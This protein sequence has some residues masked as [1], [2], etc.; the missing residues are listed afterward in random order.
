MMQSLYDNHRS[1]CL[2]CAIIQKREPLSVYWLPQKLLPP[3]TA[4]VCTSGKLMQ[5]TRFIV[6]RGP[7]GTPAA[8]TR[9]VASISQNKVIQSRQNT[10]EPRSRARQFVSRTILTS[11]NERLHGPKFVPEGF[12]QDL[13]HGSSTSSNGLFRGI[14]VNDGPEAGLLAA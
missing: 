7:V 10:A 5:V 12:N 9:N 14:V 4:L 8:K 13:V 1:M 11:S 6:M 3:R 2:V